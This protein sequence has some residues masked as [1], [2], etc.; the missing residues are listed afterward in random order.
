MFCILSSSSSSV[1]DWIAYPDACPSTPVRALGSESAHALPSVELILQASKQSVHGLSI[2]T[3]WPW[4]SDIR[5]GSAAQD[6]Q[7]MA[8]SQDEWQ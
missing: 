2:G 5:D 7:A 4:I 1:E 3:G 8:P 6:A